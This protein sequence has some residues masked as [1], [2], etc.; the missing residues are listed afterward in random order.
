MLRL[1]KKTDYGV[2]ALVYLCTHRDR[3]VSAREV[4]ERF[5]I[6]LPI[7][8]N[9]LKALSRNGLVRSVRGTNGGYQLVQAPERIRLTQVIEAL[10]GPFRLA[11]CICR[12][13]PAD[14][15]GCQ[16]LLSCPISR[17]LVQVH[18]KV[19]DLLNGVTIASL[20]AAVP[21]VTE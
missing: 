14:S 3:I 5:G 16:I 15:C 13:A 11:D 4:A 21:A 9:I 18:K 1:T 12:E 10:E 8:S 17:P 7:L 20:A 6:P 2:I 19:E